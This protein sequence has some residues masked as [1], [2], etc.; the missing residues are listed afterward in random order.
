MV[1][2]YFSGADATLRQPLSLW[3]VAQDFDVAGITNTV[4]A[5]FVRVF[6]KGA[7]VGK[8]RHH[9]GLITRPQQNSNSTRSIT[10]HPSATSGRAVAKNASM[11]HPHMERSTQRMLK[12]GHAPR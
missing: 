1:E 5:P 12:V 11:G 7:G 6:C 4:G 10:S 2:T 9:V 8:C 3:R